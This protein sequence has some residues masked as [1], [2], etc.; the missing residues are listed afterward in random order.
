MSLIL[1]NAKVR[2]EIFNIV[3]EDGIIEQ[4]TKEYRGEGV[5]LKAKPLFPDLLTFIPTAETDLP[6]WMP[7]LK[8]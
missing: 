2:G 8:N 4:I 6:Q 5:D 7:I 3:L 1:N